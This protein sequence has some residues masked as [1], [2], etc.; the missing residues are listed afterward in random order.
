MSL[1]CDMQ[2]QLVFYVAENLFTAFIPEIILWYSG[3]IDCCT[4]F[5]CAIPCMEDKVV[6]GWNTR[7]WSGCVTPWTWL[8]LYPSTLREE[9][10]SGEYGATFLYLCSR[11]S[12]TQ[13]DW[14]IWQISLMYWVFPF[15]KPLSFT[16]HSFKDLLSTPPIYWS[17]ASNFK[18]S[19]FR[20][21]HSNS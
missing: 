4:K 19:T 1:W 8:I 18:V 9:G 21:I 5:C 20:G 13:S 11:V 17:S 16:H 2:H 7:Q 15:H 3:I 6:S 10:G 14:Q 12:A